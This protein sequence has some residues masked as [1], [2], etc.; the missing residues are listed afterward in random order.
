[1]AY[2]ISEEGELFCSV[3]QNWNP[4]ED[5]RMLRFRK[6]SLH[7]FILTVSL[8]GFVR[9][10]CPVGDLSGDCQLD[11]PDLIVFAEQWLD[12]DTSGEGLV[13]HWNMDGNADDPQSGESMVHWA[14][15]V[16]EIMLTVGMTAV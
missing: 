5:K 10:G 11:L 16:M 3:F 8:V 9:A 6:I 15:T 13:A 1:V 12:T 7:T 14:L 4:Q 2:N